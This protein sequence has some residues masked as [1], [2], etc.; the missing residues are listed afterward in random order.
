MIRVM[1]HLVALMMLLANDQVE[2]ADI[3]QEN[4]GPIESDPVEDTE[5]LADAEKDIVE[6]MLGT[7]DSIYS[8]EEIDQ[9]ELDR[10]R[11]LKI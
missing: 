8:T 6:E 3:Q 1:L 9:A 11:W 7:V 10:D 5:I 2:K 4:V